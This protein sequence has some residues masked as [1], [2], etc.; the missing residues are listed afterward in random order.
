[1]AERPNSPNPALQSMRCLGIVS[2]MHDLPVD[3][4]KLALEFAP[5][6]EVN[7][8]DL[9]RAARAM[10]FRSRIVDVDPGRFDHMALPAILE[11]KDGSHLV[12]AKVENGQAVLMVPDS[13]PETVPVEELRDRITGRALL[14]TRRDTVADGSRTFGFTW[15]IPVFVK[16]RWLFAQMLLLSFFLQLF[17]L[18]A[19]LAFQVVIDKVLV[20]RGLTTLDVVVFFLFVIAV[21]DPLM[22]WLRAFLLS[23]TACRVDAEL[24]TRLFG[25]LTA[26]PMS[27]FEARPTG[28]TAAR[29]RELE[30]I[31]SFLTGS[32]LT[33]PLDVFFAI[34]FV[35]VMYHFSPRL[36]LIVLGSLPFYVLLS[37]AIA[38]VL[39]RRVED[40]F[41]KGAANHA[42]LVEVTTGIE[43]VKSL[44]VEPQIRRRW[45]N[46]L[47]AYVQ[48]SFGAARLS[49]LGSQGITLI[50]SVTVAIVLWFGAH[51]VIDGEMTVGMLV[52]FNML[53]GQLTQP[54][55]RLAHLWQDFQQ[56]RVAME[57]LGDILNQ[58]AEP[59]VSPARQSLPK[60]QGNIR[61]EDVSFR[62]GTEEREVLQDVTIEFEA[63]QTV[64]IVGRSGSGKST[65]L[66]LVQRLE[67]PSRGRILI[68]GV[69]LAMMDPALLRR[70]IGAVLQENFL[71]NRT[72]RENI[73]FS[74]PNMP[75]G[76]IMQAARLAGA[77]EFILDLRK[78]YDTVLSERGT[79]ISGG[80]RQRI[81]I[82]RTIATDPRIL[83]LDEATSS[84]DYESEQLVQSHLDRFCKGRTVFV[85]A[86]RLTTLRNADRIV[87][88][89]R[90]RFVED[91]SHDDLLK[92]GGIYASLHRKQMQQSK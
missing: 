51:A 48:A 66:R 2:A 67:S 35:A 36:T 60:L 34:V 44:A 16:Y 80:Q 40:R 71:F 29:V 47:A 46:Q 59:R 5:E 85:V 3:P 20:H 25:H 55:V 31:R 49:A 24:G 15:F 23:H 78:N 8:E 72:V 87:V 61:L 58:K 27:Y 42:F 54:V 39:R 70:Q 32:A 65:L 7:L 1:M 63:G 18:A 91:G 73:A 14:V 76:R 22:G 52:A 84:L 64:G 21:F 43:T 26:L 69:D 10:K 56:F 62:Y 83:L 37:L 68:D 86:H 53:S 13:K 9:N 45:E 28:Q 75:L 92:V 90:G 77:H 6:G 57:K 82:A 38:P 74:M 33:V 89:D 4:A 79:S 50:R 17:G 41:Q 11:G 19:P 12:L 81:A 88:L 30:T